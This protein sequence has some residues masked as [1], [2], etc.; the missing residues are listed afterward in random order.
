[1]KLRRSDLSILGD[2]FNQ[3]KNTFI[4][5][6][7]NQ[8]VIFINEYAKKLLNVHSSLSN[9]N[10][11][12]SEI[13]Q[14][15]ETKIKLDI[16]VPY[17]SKTPIQIDEVY[18]QLKIIS[19]AIDDLPVYFVIDLDV[20]E[21]HNIY[22]SLKNIF[23]ELTGETPSEMLSTQQY[24]KEVNNVMKNIL[25]KIP[26]IVYWKNT[27]FEYMGCNQAAA[28]FS[29][30]KSTTDIIGKTD[31]ELFN[32]KILADSYRTM[33]KQV[34]LE[35]KSI[36]NVQQELINPKG[37]KYYTLVSKTPLTN[38]SGQIIG[39]VGITV[40]ITKEKQAE[41]AKTEFIANMSHDIRTPLTG[42]IGMSEILRDK[43]ENIEHK[44]DAAILAESGQQLLK[45]LNEILDDVRSDNLS[46]TDITEEKFDLYQCITDLIKLE[47]PTTESKHLKLE[48]KIEPNVP[49]FIINDRKKIT[50]ILLNLLGNAI[51]FTQ[52]GQITVI[53]KCLDSTE[54]DAHLEFSVADT[55]IGI[56]KEVQNK[57]FERFFRVDPSYKGRYSGY[58][59]GLH[60]VQTYVNLLDGHI[61]LTSNE[62]KGSTFHFDLRCK[63]AQ[64]KNIKNNSMDISI[65]P[66]SDLE[67]TTK[68][69]SSVKNANSPQILLIED[70]ELALKVLE[71]IVQTAG[72]GFL[73]A[74][75]AEEALKLAQYNTFELIITDIGLPG[76]SGNEFTKQFR[77][78]E[79]TRGNKPI[80]I[81]GLTGHAQDITW[82]ESMAA[83]M[84]NL[85]S[86]PISSEIFQQ[87]VNKYLQ[88]NN[89]K[90]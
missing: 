18:K 70:S 33:D 20:T 78:L 54:T 85:F 60:I 23:K 84:D 62:N 86:K 56:P 87:I 53:V 72:F 90:R 1:M 4:V 27:K 48:Y 28:D 49:Q 26:C 88:N 9:F 43:V 58:G 11:Y 57:I 32:D 75:T 7:E 64:D 14:N 19:G 34:I 51:K 52:K 66:S 25:D 77:I 2:A 67:I 44:H 3:L 29:G 59:L 55:G 22:L 69:E 39:I 38:K 68:T 71:I 35:R 50:H 63:I 65:N 80:P 42:V 8:T 73:S 76:I 31:Y 47:S 41:I 36:I 16:N 40:D 5:I 13:V 15:C 12:F 45:M 17:L 6:D 10:C 81:I 24:L 61:T 46:E 89:K 82:L 37:K 21:Q 83:G 30:L 74:T 79:K